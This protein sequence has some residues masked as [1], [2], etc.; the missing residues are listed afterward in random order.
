MTAAIPRRKRRKGLLDSR[1]P[2]RED[3]FGLL[4][5]WPGQDS[6]YVPP[7]IAVTHP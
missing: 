3:C 4:M 7:A 2:V 5:H 1:K 6:H